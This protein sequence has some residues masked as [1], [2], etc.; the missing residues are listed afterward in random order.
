MQ[1]A[2]D[3]LDVDVGGLLG[4]RQRLVVDRQVV[5][6]VLAETGRLGVV[7]RHGIAVHTAQSVL[8]D[9]CDLERERRVIGDHRRIAGGE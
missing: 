9:V 6:D 8:D 1:P 4:L 7:V 2:Q 3:A 5:E